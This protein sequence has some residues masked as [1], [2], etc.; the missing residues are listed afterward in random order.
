[1]AGNPLSP[2]AAL[3]P[4]RAA[5]E[6][7]ALIASAGGAISSTVMLAQDDFFCGSDDEKTMVGL[8]RP[9]EAFTGQTDGSPDV[10]FNPDNASGG[11]WI[12]LLLD[13]ADEAQQAAVSSDHILTS[14]K[15]TLEARVG[16]T[17]HT[18]ATDARFF[19]ALGNAALTTDLTGA[20]NWF[21]LAP[22]GKTMT[23]TGVPATVGSIFVLKLDF[24]DMTAIKYFING[25][26]VGPTYST[27]DSTANALLE[28]RK[29]GGANSIYVIADYMTLSANRYASNVTD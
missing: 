2:F 26:Q 18:S 20:N 1:M 8:A 9:F 24:T 19:L 12:K 15:P 22:D 5:Q 21:T 10:S 11:G 6:L 27:N 7:E 25:V 23:D 14:Q 16:I 4:A 13:S 29:T 3:D 28:L 17:E